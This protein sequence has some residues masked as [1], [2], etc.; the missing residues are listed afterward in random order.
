MLNN[1]DMKFPKIKNE[2]GKEVEP[3]NFLADIRIVA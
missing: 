1:A 3:Q 2:D